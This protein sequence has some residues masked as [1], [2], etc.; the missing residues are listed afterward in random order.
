MEPTLR[1]FLNALLSVVGAVT[2]SDAEYDLIFEKASFE[3]SLD[4]YAALLSVLDSRDMVSNSRDRL[5]Y[6]FLA[7][8]IEVGEISFAKSN[9]FFGGPLEN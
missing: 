3:F 1:D 8:G 7:R 6:Y 2:L 5:R 9:I 4:T